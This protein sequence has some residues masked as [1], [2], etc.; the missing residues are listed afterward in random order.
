MRVEFVVLFRVGSK[1][2]TS[3]HGTYFVVCNRA[4]FGCILYVPYMWSRPVQMKLRQFLGP[5]FA[6]S[7]VT[8]FV[9]G[10]YHNCK[11][12]NAVFLLLYLTDSWWV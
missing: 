6:E 1:D 11:R 9:G 2:F 7:N 4:F 12:H 10:H 8:L 5:V 3:F